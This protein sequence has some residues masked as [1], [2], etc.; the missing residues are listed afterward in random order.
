M[1]HVTCDQLASLIQAGSM[2]LLDFN[3]SYDDKICPFLHELFVIIEPIGDMAANQLCPLS[4]M[5]VS[6]ML[7]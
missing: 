2:R 4:F 7:L 3:V 1:T 5:N 6:G